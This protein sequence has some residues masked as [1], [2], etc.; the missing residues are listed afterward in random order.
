[1]TRG[2]KTDIETN[3]KIREMYL[4]NPS[5]STHDIEEKLTGTEYEC[6]HDTIGRILEE[7]RQL[8]TTEQGRIQIQRLD[9][10]ISGIEALTAKAVTTLQLK[11]ELSV[12]DVKQLNDIAKN[13]FDRKQLLTGKPTERIDIGNL[14]EFT[15]SEL[16]AMTDIV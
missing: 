11:E 6:S 8:A 16:L 13:N 1:M 12:N 2:K 9:S 5:L 10:I 15:T 4:L 3:A 7:L 14:K